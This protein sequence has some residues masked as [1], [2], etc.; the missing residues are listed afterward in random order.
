MEDL[1]VVAILVLAIG[2]AVIYIIK[3]KKKGLTYADMLKKVK[4]NKEL[5]EEL[6]KKINAKENYMKIKKWFT[7]N[8]K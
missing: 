6:Q 7:D 8:V 1:I 2:A 3:E 4:G 5:S